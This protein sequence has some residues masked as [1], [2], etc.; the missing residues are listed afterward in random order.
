MEETIENL[1]QSLSEYINGID[2]YNDTDFSNDKVVNFTQNDINEYKMSLEKILEENQVKK[3]E[4]LENQNFINDIINNYIKLLNCRKKIP[5]TCDSLFKVLKEKLI[6]SYNMVINQF[7]EKSKEF[8]EDFSSMIDLIQINITQNKIINIEEKK[9]L[10]IDKLNLMDYFFDIY[11][12]KITKDISD[13]FQEFYIRIDN[14][15]IELNKDKCNL[16]FLKTEINNI[17]DIYEKKYKELNK[18][19]EIDINFYNKELSSIL[20]KSNAQEITFEDNSQNLMLRMDEVVDMIFTIPFSNIGLIASLFFSVKGLIEKLVDY[21]K[22]K[23]TIK[24]ELEQFRISLIIQ[25]KTYMERAMKYLSQLDIRFRKKINK[26]YESEIISTYV[27]KDKFQK[28]YDDL[29]A[30]LKNITK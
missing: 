27:N 17:Y 26:L 23:D 2:S 11:R 21:M 25:S 16:S 22:K 8:K 10:K 6:I 1:I 30:A 14:V 7:K 12:K 19:L 3:E 4:I 24:K 20:K 18:T 28:I 29:R 15:L 13:F 9:K 5:K